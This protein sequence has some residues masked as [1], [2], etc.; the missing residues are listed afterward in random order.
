MYRAYMLKVVIFLGPTHQQPPWETAPIFTHAFS[1]TNVVSCFQPERF[2]PAFTK[3]Y[4]MH[5]MQ[6]H[7]EITIYYS[8]TNPITLVLPSLLTP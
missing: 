6:R 3:I 7:D 5:N 2:K 4:L 8:F 1:M